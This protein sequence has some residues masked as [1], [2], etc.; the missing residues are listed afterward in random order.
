MSGCVIAVDGGGS[1]TS[2]VLLRSGCPVAFAE[3]GPSNPNDIGEDAAAETVASLCRELLRKAGES[4]PSAVYAGIS[5]ILGHEEY[6]ASRLRAEFSCPVSAVSDINNLFGFLPGDGDAA[7]LVCGSG[8]VCFLRRGGELIRIGGWG[9]LVD[10]ICGGGFAIGR[11]GLEAAFR[12][13]D[14]RGGPTGLSAVAE[15]YLGVPA[16]GPAATR[17]IYA[18]GKPLVAGFATYVIKTAESDAAARSI[19]AAAADGAAEMAAAAGK[20]AGRSVDCVCGGGLFREPLFRV[21]FVSS[22]EKRCP[23]VRPVF[24]GAPQLAGAAAAALR[25]AGQPVPDGL[26]E[27]F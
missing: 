19:V 13:A 20:A 1:G 22:L 15:E 6:M 27:R 16:D 26:P 25:F 4:R 14:G 7:A 3:G 11:S 10:G 12:A 21:D 8:C 23:S 2:A 5:G 17:V 18:G 24:P 9:Y